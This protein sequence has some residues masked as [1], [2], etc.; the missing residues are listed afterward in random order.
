MI[1][2]AGLIGIVFT[3]S[4]SF[5]A[6][7]RGF[8]KFL[9]TNPICITA[10]NADGPPVCLDMAT[11]AKAFNYVMIARLENQNIPA[12]FVGFFWVNPISFYFEK[13]KKKV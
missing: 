1:A 4:D 6:H 7:H 13:K 8:N 10:P 9:G 5:V 11:S 2:E 12:F 3:H